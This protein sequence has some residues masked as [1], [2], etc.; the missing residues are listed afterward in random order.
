LAAEAA[1]AVYETG[2]HRVV[3]TCGPPH[4]A[5]E[6]GRLVA[7]TTGL[8]LVLDMRDP[9]SLQQRLTEDG[10]SPLWFRL[11]EHYE[12]RAVR[13]S[14]LIVMN[15]PA[16]ARAMAQAYPGKAVIAVLN[17]C[18]EEAFPPTPVRNRFVIAYAGSIYL[19]R[20]PGPI[21]GAAAKIIKTLGLSPDQFGLEFIGSASQYSGVSLASMAQDLGIAEYVSVLPTMPRAAAM[22]RLSHAAVLLSLP[23]DSSLAIPSKVYEYCR[24]EAWLLALSTP[25]TATAEL[26]QGTT[27]DV[28]VPNDLDQIANV[29]EKRYLEFRSGARPLAIASDH[30]FSRRRQAEILFG[31]LNEV[32]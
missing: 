18:D 13:R 14:C 1:T 15:T 4:L 12:R 9:W 30:R 23:Q 22:D 32:V 25:E 11:A 21:L 19:D 31:A 24:F 28:V 2:V 8:P 27:A 20:D 17:G 6:A 7:E 5:H 26:L 29:L 16:A 3:V 10:A